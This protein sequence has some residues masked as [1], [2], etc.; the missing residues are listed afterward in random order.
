MLI[1]VPPELL[2]ERLRLR[3]LQ[4]SDAPALFSAIDE[5]R[6]TLESWLNWPAELQSV[7][8]VEDFCAMSRTKWEQRTQLWYGVLLHENDRMLGATGLHDL[9]WD[10]RAFQIGYW[11]RTSAVGHGYAQEAVEAL[12]RMAFRDLR[13]Q[14]LEIRC[15]PH[16]ER[17]RQVAE[18][19]GFVL[20]GRLRKATRTPAGRPRDTLVFSRIDDDRH[21]PPLR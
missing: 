7:A 4:R 14:R 5:S 15:D 20:E 19:G 17:S 9:D 12:V 11:L 13:A 2:T 1:P 10:C 21:E 18:R 6:R 16:N 8:D 3:P